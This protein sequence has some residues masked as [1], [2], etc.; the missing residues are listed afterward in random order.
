MIIFIGDIHGEFYDLSNK[1]ANTNIKDSYFIQ[2]GD[3][4]LGFMK[5]ENETA[6]LNVLNKHLKDANN[7]M[8]IIRGNHDNPAYFKN[9]SGYSNIEFLKDYSVLKIA[10]LN[11]LLAGGA[12]SIDRKSR[13][14]GSSYWQDEEFVYRESL[15]E[16]ALEGLKSVD[17]VVTHNS[18]AE[19]Y[20]QEIN[21]SVIAWSKRDD[22]L[23][24]DL[25]KERYRHTMLLNFLVAKNL[26]PKHWYYGHFHTS[27][28][29]SFEDIYYRILNCSE[30]FEHRQSNEVINIAY[31]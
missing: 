27:H 1:L 28:F 31:K 7:Q 24:S 14:I 29:E 21:S 5:Q 16:K 18:P 9:D 8:Y 17:I 13:K 20:P 26:K 3:F 22:Q 12:I 2:V 11:I 23:L 25:N 15:V 4:G 30:F 6:Q 10:G 19:F